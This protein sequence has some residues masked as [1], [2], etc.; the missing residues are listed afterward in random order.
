MLAALDAAPRGQPT[1]RDLDG[2]ADAGAGPAIWDALYPLL[3][4]AILAPALGPQ[5]R[6]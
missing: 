5:G 4:D 3:P 6:S 1:R 2:K